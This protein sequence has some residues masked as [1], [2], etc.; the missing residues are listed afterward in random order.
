MNQKSTFE[1]KIKASGDNQRNLNVIFLGVIIIW[2]LCKSM[3]LRRY[4][5][6]KIGLK[7]MMSATFKW[8]RKKKMSEKATK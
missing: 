1:L 4:I 6:K 7:V 3:L 2:R 5:L 8:F